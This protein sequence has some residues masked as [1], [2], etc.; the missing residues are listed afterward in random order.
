LVAL[1]AL[2]VGSVWFLWGRECAR[3]ALF[4]ALLTLFIIPIGFLLGHTEPLQRLVAG[5]VE[6]MS[7]LV[8][9]T[10][11]RDGVKLVSPD[12]SIQCEVAGGCSGIRSIVAMT[13]LSL[14]YVHFSDRPF[15]KKAL[16]FAMT[17]PFAVLGNVF[18]VFTIILVSKWFGS[19]AGTG[20]W[21]DISGFVVTIPI[22][23]MAMIWFGELL[24]REWTPLK[25]KLLARDAPRVAL[26]AAP[27]SDAGEAAEKPA[28]PSSPISYDY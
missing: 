11:N 24:D 15:W 9:I 10:V 17:L 14:L 28:S 18:R 12:G 19:A 13:M 26:A 2:V 5:I 16:I 7:Y 1:P 23:V 4:P 6:K 21:H 8:G 27:S 25:E 22:A 3:I 20:P